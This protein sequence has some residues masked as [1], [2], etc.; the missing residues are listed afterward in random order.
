MKI[1]KKQLKSIIREEKVRLLREQPTHFS[2][3]DTTL[4]VTQDKFDEFV[5]IIANGPYGWIDPD[6]VA[7]QW[8]GTFGVH[9]ISTAARDYLI[10]NLD[11]KGLIGDPE[12]MGE[13]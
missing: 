9:S 12:E 4:E 7:R 8:E 1:T 6:D 10:W 2:P 3:G 11:A 5:A 13:Y